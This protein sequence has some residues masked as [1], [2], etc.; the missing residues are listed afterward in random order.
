MDQT[1]FLELKQVSKRFAGVLANDGIDL[2]FYPGEIH[3]ILGENGAGKSTLMNLIA[4]LM[5]PDGGEILLKRE[6]VVFRNPREAMQHGIGMVH[7]HFM[8]INAFTV[9]ENVILGDEPRRWG[10]IKMAQGRER[11]K[12]LCGRYGFKVHPDDRVST[13]SVGLKQ[14]VEIMKTLYRS[15]SLLILDEPTALLTPSETGRLFE[16]MRSLSAAGVSV[17]FITHKLKEVMAVS[18]RITVMRRG[19]VVAHSLAAAT[20]EEKLISF[21]IGGVPEKKSRERASFPES[22]FFEIRNLDLV[23]E[24]G[25]AIVQN[26]SF[27]LRKGEILGI[28]GVQGNG[29]TELAEAIQGLR[30]KAKGEML[31]E[32]GNLPFS[33]PRKLMDQGVSHVPEDR[34]RDG[35]ILS[36]PVAF[37]QVLRSYNK[38]PFSSKG[39]LNRKAIYAHSERLNREYDIRGASPWTPAGCLSGGNQQKVILSRELEP[40]VKILLLN[41]PTRGLDVGAVHSVYNRILELRNKGIGILL[42]SSDLDEIFYLA[43]RIM[44]LYK[45]KITGEMLRENADREIIGNLM[46]GGKGSDGRV[47]R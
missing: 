45:G 22:P 26:M 14:Q 17:I 29:Q 20:D 10:L 28:A 19:R 24:D 41:Q 18:D 7:Q 4:G 40:G 30:P 5:R 3:S 2:S 9:M 27:K 35:L 11:V 34:Q 1:P 46:G 21:L 6:T 44:V 8:L 36:F 33:N 12:A 23:N 39:V 47:G 38:K 15:A 31:L 16:M 13:L 42:I 25:T 37:N 32:G 43:D